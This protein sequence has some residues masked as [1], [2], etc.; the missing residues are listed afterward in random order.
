MNLK[1][2]NSNMQLPLKLSQ[3]K[4][5]DALRLAIQS[6][7]AAALT[8]ILMHAMHLPEIFV[9]V[10]SAVLIVEP[11][12]GNT[13]NAAKGRIVSTLVGTVI[14]FILLV[15]IPWGFGTAI[16]LAI[17]MF[18]L[19]G[20]S[21]FRP[22]W[23]YGVVAA[24]AIALGSESDAWETAMYRIIS[25]GIGIIVGIIVS[26]IVMPK[27]AETLTMRYLNEAFR[28]IHHFFEASINA[29]R[30]DDNSGTEHAQRFQNNIGKAK[31]AA[32]A[33]SF[34]EKDSYDKQI[35]LAKKLY[36]SILIIHRISLKT[37]GNVTD[38]DSGIENDTE[39]LKEHILSL[40]NDL[41]NDSE[42]DVS[43]SQLSDQ[44]SKVKEN[45]ESDDSNMDITILRNSFVFA[46][47]ET[48][49]SLKKLYELKSE[50]QAKN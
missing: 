40:I 7:L 41:S 50:K 18:V 35:E 28:A 6:A 37:E 38:G 31:S 9:G 15:L 17:A 19:N 43:L 46:I 13:F 21:S 3:T 26:F 25:I 47:T 44:I 14:G 16:S 33:I 11:S 42:N 2:P 22:N 36:N 48:E 20:I 32:N 29:T 27:K 8:Y 23:R 1:I 49:D 45:F 12:I 39:K 5:K 4:I 34:N 30:S 10:L 24:V